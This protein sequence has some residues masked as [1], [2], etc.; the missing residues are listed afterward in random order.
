MED[1]KAK[2]SPESAATK[3]KKEVVEEVK[4]RSDRH[5]WGVIIFLLL[6]SVISLYSAS[7]REVASSANVYGPIL[8]HG[9][10]LLAGL[11]IMIVLERVHYRFFKPVIPIFAAASVVMMVYVLIAGDI[12]NGARRSFTF[13]GVMIQPAEFLKM[14]S[15]LVIA[16]IMSR[17]QEPNG[18]KTKG[19]LWSALSVILFSGL[20]FTQGLTNTILLMAI[21]LSMMMIGGVQFKKLALVLVAYAVIGGAALGYKMLSSESRAAEAAAGTQVEKLDRS[22][23]WQARVERFIGDGKPKYEQDITPENRQ[24]MYSYFAQAN[25]GIFG[26]FP[27]NSREASRLPLAFSDYIYAIIIEESGM[28]GGLALIVVYMWLLTRSGRIAGRCRKSFPALLVLGLAVMIVFQALFHMGIVTGVFPVSGQPLPLIS[29]GGSSILIT[30]IAFGM[31]LS[32]SRYGM[33]PRPKKNKKK[34]FSL[35]KTSTESD[36]ENL[37]KL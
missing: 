16:L 30:S 8:R 26:Q 34:K 32:V 18:V 37:A 14:S 33:Q 11:V 28:F 3:A 13:L 23:T 24:E 4:P 9:G 1:L 6:V 22:T 29:K 19:V 20:L 10:M 21:S 36:G 5:I 35:F 25:G 12:I 27:G 31:M 15:V 7:S 17:M 2:T